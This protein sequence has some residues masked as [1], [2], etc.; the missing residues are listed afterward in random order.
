MRGSKGEVYNAET[1][2]VFRARKVDGCMLAL[3]RPWRPAVR[4]ALD[5]VRKSGEPPQAR[6]QTEH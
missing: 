1:K 4:S 5:I 3:A 6:Q 2:G